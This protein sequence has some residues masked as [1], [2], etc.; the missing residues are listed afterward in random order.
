[1]AGAAGLR[2]GAPASSA[3][4]LAAGALLS[5]SP[6]GYR[7]RGRGRSSGRGGSRSRGGVEPPRALPP[8][9]AI[10]CGRLLRRLAA[11]RARPGGARGR[12]ASPLDRQHE[13]LAI[14]VREVIV[15]RE[16]DLKGVED[17][18]SR[19]FAR[20]SLAVRARHLRHRRDHPAVLAILKANGHLERARRHV[21]RVAMGPR[22]RIERAACR[23]APERRSE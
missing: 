3:P 5:V 6:S 18:G 10:S 2:I 7:R 12:G 1:M 22:R 14:T 20:A 15:R 23:R 21:T 9:R 8:A 19:F 17:V 16:H 11:R 13:R 4:A